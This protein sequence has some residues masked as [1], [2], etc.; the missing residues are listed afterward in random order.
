MLTNRKKKQSAPGQN[1][2]RG[3]KLSFQA[4]RRRFSLPP[5]KRTVSIPPPRGKVSR[6][7]RREA[8]H[9]PCFQ[10]PKWCASD[11]L[12]RTGQPAP[13]PLPPRSG[14]APYCSTT[15]A[16][17]KSK[18]SSQYIPPIDCAAS[19]KRQSGFKMESRERVPNM[20]PA[21][22]TIPPSGVQPAHKTLGAYSPPSLP[23]KN[24]LRSQA[25]SR[26]YRTT[27]RILSDP[28]S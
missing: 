17:R 20:P 7:V 19:R 5:P 23:S 10:Q 21:A 24:I 12:D 4:H 6:A 3:G 25:P 26:P 27:R 22:C 2:Y 11:H 13:L 14:G 15:A 16:H 18:A 1:I 8:K 9:E 28:A